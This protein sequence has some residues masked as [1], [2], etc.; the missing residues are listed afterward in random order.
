VARPK[1]IEVV[2]IVILRLRKKAK[3]V[4]DYKI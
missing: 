3:Y 2:I 4:F 1:S